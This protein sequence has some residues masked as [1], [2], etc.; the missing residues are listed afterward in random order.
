MP[1]NK[2]T[3]I[4]L[5][6]EGAIHISEDVVAAIAALAASEC[7]GVV[8][9]ASGGPGDLLGKK[10]LT[11]GIKLV[12]EENKVNVDVYMMIC[13]GYGIPAVAAK[14]QEKIKSSIESMTGLQI[15]NINV[16]V[17]G[18]LFEKESKK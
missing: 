11:K 1:D 7:E 10:N 9:T 4:R 3:V 18:I 16:H 14:V 12:I 8:M 5:E 13:Y 6:D 2:D 15:G 17:G